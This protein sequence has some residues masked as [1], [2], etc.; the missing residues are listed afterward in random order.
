[1]EM[2]G[3][4]GDIKKNKRTTLECK[5]G[6]FQT[7]KLSDLKAPSIP[8]EGVERRRAVGGTRKGQLG[9]GWVAV[10]LHT[11]REKKNRPQGERPSKHEGRACY[12]DFPDWG[13]GKKDGAGR[14]KHNKLVSRE[15]A[16]SPAFRDGKDW[17]EKWKKKKIEVF[18]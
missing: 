6:Q 9:K 7:L 11:S 12:A 10:S 17:G 4:G 8:Q 14:E 15:E 2:G 16:L 1:V 18:N 3:G 5:K 13:G